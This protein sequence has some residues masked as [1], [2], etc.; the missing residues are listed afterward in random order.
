MSIMIILVRSYFLHAVRLSTLTTIVS[1][2]QV[3]LKVR[4]STHA[5]DRTFS[6]E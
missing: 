4:R 5:L 1:G 2:I 6:V 3:H